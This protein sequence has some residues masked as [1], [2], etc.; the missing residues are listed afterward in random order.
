MHNIKDVINIHSFQEA[1]EIDPMNGKTPLI[2]RTVSSL[3]P[4]CLEVIYARIFQ[5]GEAVMIEKHCEE[6]GDFKDIYWS[7]A[8]IYRRFMRYQS[9]WMGLTNSP[10]ARQGC[11]FECGLCKNHK[12][13]TLLGIID[14]TSR[15]NLSCPICFADAGDELNEPTIS[16]IGA[17]MQV[18]RD[19]MPVPCPAI[20]FSGGEPTLRKDLSEIVFLA[21]KMGFAQIQV[22]TNGI[23]LAVK[24]DLCK[25]LVHSGLSTIYLQFDGVTPE[26]YKAIRGCDLLPAKLRAIENLRAAG[27]HSIVLVP[28]LVKGTNDSQVGDIVKFASKNL[29]IVKGINYQPV[30]FTGRIDQEER[31][32]KRITIPDVL[33]LLEDQTDNEITRDDFYPIPFVEPISHLIEA[34]TGRSQ[35]VFTAHPCCGAGTYIYCQ[36]GHMIPITRFL[37]VEGL[38]E[39]IRQEI[40][41]FDG[42]MLGKLKMNG[43]ILKHMPRFVDELRAPDNFNLKEL[44]L[45]VFINGTRESLAEFHN[46][47]LFLG[48]MHFQDRYNIDLE[49]LERCGIHYAMPDGRIIPFCSYNIFHRSRLRNNQ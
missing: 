48:I 44:I 46:R 27:Q 29:E 24:P 40:D 12:T 28:T 41:C 16:Q 36:G 37:D 10:Q 11:P 22:A 13:G 35:P 1:K 47:F 39:K 7:D 15:C 32:A 42:S 8:T 31:A 23:M 26:P 4:V 20:Q 25:D 14:V 45:S 5:E 9:D 6:H 30:S 21:R 3:C 18:L 19:Q 33:A 43:M 38:M 49:K 17:M 34:E 2:T